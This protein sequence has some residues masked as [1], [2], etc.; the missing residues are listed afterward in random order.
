[1]WD[2]AG[3]NIIEHLA[4]VDDFEVAEATYRAAVRRWPKA[5][6]ALRQGARGVNRLPEEL[7]ACSNFD[8]AFLV[9]HFYGIVYA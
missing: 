2:D 9:L 7:F 5:V 3:E 6:I 8:Q 4:G 1:M